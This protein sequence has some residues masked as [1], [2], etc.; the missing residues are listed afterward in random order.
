MGLPEFS[1]EGYV[2]VEGDNGVAP[3]NDAVREDLVA[4]G[5]RGLK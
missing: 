4:R 2:V 3:L 5:S 1:L